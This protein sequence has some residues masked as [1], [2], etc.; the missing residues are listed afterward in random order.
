MLDNVC[1]KNLFTNDN[2]KLCQ[3]LTESTLTVGLSKAINYLANTLTALQTV[4]Q[5]GT[6]VENFNDII[7]LEYQFIFPLVEHMTK[8]M[9]SELQRENNGF[10]YEYTTIAIIMIILIGL[11]FFYFMRYPAHEI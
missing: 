10:E 3:N 2:A 9:Y 1:R 6:L 5:N 4:P 8:L 7:L 11:N